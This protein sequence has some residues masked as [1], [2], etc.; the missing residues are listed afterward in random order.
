[1][2]NAILKSVRYHALDIWRGIVCLVV[3]LEHAAVCL[4][5]GGSDR[6][7]GEVYWAR[8]WLV[9]VLSWNLGAPL[10]FVISGYCIAASLDSTRR[11][12]ISPAVF[13]ARRLWRIFP[14]YWASMLIIAMVITVLN[15]VGLRHWHVTQVGLELF[16]LKT[17]HLD[18]WIGN[19]TLTETWRLTVAQGS[20][21]R[22]LNRVAWALCY[23]EQFY[24]VCFLALVFAPKRLYKALALATIG[25]IGFRL[26][27]S[28]VGSERYYAGLFPDLWHQFAVGLALY[29][30][31]NVAEDFWAKRTIEALLIVMVVT[32]AN[33]GLVT[34]QAAGI[35]GLMLLV[36]HRWD[37]AIANIK[38]FDP[39]RA[40]GKRSYSVYL[41][42][43]PVC[44]VGN[45]ALTDAGLESFWLRAGIMMPAVT[46]GSVLAGWIFYAAV[47]R[48]FSNLPIVGRFSRLVKPPQPGVA[49]PHAQV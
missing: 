15:V 8:D 40:L 10:F 13:L 45:A 2:D 1:M 9:Q 35:F 3:V 42:H 49:I 23:Q 28:T 16:D 46:A 7:V 21:P 41:I 26:W 18:Q 12:G 25:I 33:T 5:G 39:L 11:K 4:W 6:V 43:L 44:T 36:F 20:E 37:L 38:Q 14:P 30:R 27:T 24:M 32:G 34:T 29:W 19:I 31:I 22:L 17:F 48:H 47:D